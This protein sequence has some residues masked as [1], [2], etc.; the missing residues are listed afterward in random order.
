MGD[1]EALRRTAGCAHMIEASVGEEAPERK[2][3]GCP[4]AE[5]VPQ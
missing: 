1:T 5:D 3:R 4:E 2:Q